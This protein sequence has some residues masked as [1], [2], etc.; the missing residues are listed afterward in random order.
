MLGN[1]PGFILSSDAFFQNQLFRNILSGLPSVS[2][3]LYLDQAGC[4][5]EPDLGS[6]CLQRLS[7]PEGNELTWVNLKIYLLMPCLSEIIY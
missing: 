3:G 1:F 4:S 6:N 5:V 2:D 7:L